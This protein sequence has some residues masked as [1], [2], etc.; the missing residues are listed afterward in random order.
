MRLAIASYRKARR[1]LRIWEVR[2]QRLIELN[3]PK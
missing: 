1:L 3:A 2:T